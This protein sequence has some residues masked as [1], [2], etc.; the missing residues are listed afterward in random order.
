MSEWVEGVWSLAHEENMPEAAVQ[1][2]RRRVVG[3]ANVIGKMTDGKHRVRLME[4]KGHSQLVN[5]QTAPGLFSK[6][7]QPRG[8]RKGW[9][10]PLW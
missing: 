2:K 7:A 3:S 9:W 1:E 5:E 8:R 10:W 4:S 6:T